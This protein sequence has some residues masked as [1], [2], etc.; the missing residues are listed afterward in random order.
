MAGGELYA[1]GWIGSALLSAVIASSK[2]RSGCAW[3]AL[4]VAAGPLAL[5]ASVLMPAR[6]A[7]GDPPGSAEVDPVKAV[8]DRVP[9]DGE[10]N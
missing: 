6:T 2:N 8:G 7:Q 4:G 1:F 9:S 3:C 10:G 5:L